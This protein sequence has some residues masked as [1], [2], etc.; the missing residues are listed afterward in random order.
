MAE[1]STGVDVDLDSVTKSFQ[2]KRALNNVSLHV[3]RGEFFTLLGPSGCGKTTILRAIAGFVGIE[4]GS[5]RFNGA[6]MTH[7]QP[8]RRNIGFVFQN[9][10][11]WPNRT[12]FE[13]V[14]FGLR[15]RKL[16]N[17]IVRRKV[18]EILSLVELNGAEQLFPGEL[19]GGMQQRTAIARALVI[20]PNLLLLDEPLSNLDA[21]LRVSLRRE[22]QAIQKRLS[23]TTIYVTHDQE[24]ALEISD[25]IAVMH[26]GR[27]QQIG[28]PE[29]IY[30]EP[31]TRFVAEFVGSVNLIYGIFSDKG[32]FA[33][34][35][36]ISLRWPDAEKRGWR[37]AGYLCIRPEDFRLIHE[38]ES[39]H[40]EGI[41]TQCYYT[42]TQRRYELTGA[43][44][45]QQIVFTSRE[46]LS[47]HQKVQLGIERAVWLPAN[48]SFRE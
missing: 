16:P 32:L 22:I 23:V 21:K 30:S 34:N 6:E 45:G 41:V 20:E 3:A 9:Y 15:L 13:N 38:R 4:S 10:A 14:A 40:F 26:E 2:A 5:I 44:S 33:A 27:V 19:S 18:T 17:E 35:S 11:L 8:W 39:Q 42:G 43:V 7:V 12:V 31:K 37:G 46:P 28:K 48:D 25:R 29:E 36:G 24:E 47:L 1:K